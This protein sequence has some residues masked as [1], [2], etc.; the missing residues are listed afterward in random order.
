MDTASPESL[1]DPMLLMVAKITAVSGADPDKAE[2]CLQTIRDVPEDDGNLIRGM[3]ARSRGHTQEARQWL[4]KV[5]ESYEALI[6]LGG[7]F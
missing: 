3:I 2:V 6:I 4:E 5:P 7:Y 1:D